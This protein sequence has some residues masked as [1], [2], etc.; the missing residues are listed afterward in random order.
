MAAPI[1]IF[2]H[3]VFFAGE[4][5]HRLPSARQ[6]VCEQMDQLAKSGLLEAAQ[7]FVVGINGG[8]E[9][10][11]YVTRFIP[12]KAQCVFHGLQ[13][14]NECRTMALIEDWLSEH[15][16]WYVLYFHSKGAT[17]DATTPYG[18]HCMRWRR[19]M[20]NTC[21]ARWRECVKALS[22]GYEAVGAHWLTNRADGSQNYFGGTFWWVTSRF[23]QTLPSLYERARIKL[24]GIDS[25]D[26]RYEAEVWIGT[27]PR[28]PLVRD[29]E[30]SHRIF[31]CP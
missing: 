7:H 25:V 24:S 19:C 21:V 28:L 16:G 30:T 22:D 31:C 13:C 20:M 10:L 5:P 23:L 29:M 15:D 27:G 1:A 4:P 17:H 3:V 26:S 2:Y 8:E 18:L 11:E 6:I 9:S 12:T 14:R